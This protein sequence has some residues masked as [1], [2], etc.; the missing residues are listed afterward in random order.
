VEDE[1]EGVSALGTPVLVAHQIVEELTSEAAAHEVT[2]TTE[3][4][5]EETSDDENFEDVY[6]DV[7]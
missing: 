1:P 3:I 7:N 4:F 2:M 6:E 5:Q